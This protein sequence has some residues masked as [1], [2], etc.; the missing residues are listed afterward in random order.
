MW[1]SKKVL[2]DNPAVAAQTDASEDVAVEHDANK[3]HKQSIVFL[4][5]PVGP[6]FSRVAK[7]FAK[8]GF[9]VHKINFNGGDKF[10]Y[11]RANTVDYA[12]SPE[13]WPEYLKIFIRRH[14]ISR[15][16]VFGDCRIYHQKAKE[17]A[18]ELGID[19][20]VFE[21]GYIRPNYITLEKNGVNGYSSLMD[22]PALFGS[23][24]QAD[25]PI[26]AGSRY[27]FCISAF[28][29]MLYYMAARSR[30]HRFPH[31][32]HHRPFG[33]LKEGA[34]WV[35]SGFRKVLNRQAGQKVTRIL[36][37]RWQNQYFLCPL[38]VHCDM[39]VLVHS[40]Y[41]SI[42]EFICEV[43]TSFAKNASKNHALVF[44]HHPYDRGY[45]NYSPLI[46]QLAKAL[47]ID[48]RTFYVHDVNLPNLI[49]NADGCVMINSTV[50]MSSLYHKTPVK[51]MGNAVYDRKGLTYQ[52][53]LDNFW[54]KPGN[55]DATAAA[56]F[57]AFLV[58]NNQL[59]GSLYRRCVKDSSAGVVWA[60]K[61]L[62]EHSPEANDKTSTQRFSGVRVIQGLHA[63]SA[64]TVFK[65]PDDDELSESA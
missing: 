29:S 19:Y 22:R 24:T 64:N 37:N 43:M 60:G 34:I 7:D 30:Q 2:P 16:Y 31:Y 49:K 42:D 55:V 5:G 47:H 50:G 65:D 27:S 21:E 17:V 6:F 3:V 40:P 61:L 46:E 62:A 53:K 51:V 28:Y 15:I 35:R 14:A 8:R 1:R 45:T 23:T 59:N 63:A 13:R 52:G 26:S 10:F 38:Q 39:Q 4:Q 48:E 33:W 18:D 36:D 54:K 12:D 9:E 56:A 58:R 25:T 32:E 44:K 57:R 20:F 41:A 11:N